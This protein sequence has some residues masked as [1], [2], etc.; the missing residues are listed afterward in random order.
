M[1]KRYAKTKEREH[2]R[3]AAPRARELPLKAA[4]KKKK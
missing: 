4:K 3:T 1:L 2:R